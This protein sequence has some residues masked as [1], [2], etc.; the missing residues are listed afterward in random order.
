MNLPNDTTL[1]KNRPRGANAIPVPWAVQPPQG[2]K[3]FW[4]ALCLSLL[5]HL[6]FV[7]LYRPFFNA[8]LLPI[9]TP[10]APKLQE[11]FQPIVFEL[12]ETPADAAV[13]EP[14]ND[15][16]FFSDKNARASDLLERNDLVSGMPYSTGQTDYRV[17]SGGGEA[18]PQESSVQPQSPQPQDQQL[19]LEQQVSRRQAVKPFH[20]SML[21]QSARNDQ[22]TP[23]DFSD[24]VDFNQQQFSADALGDVSLNT[25][26]WD[27]APYLLAMKNKIRRNVY[28]PPA[29]SQMGMISG[30][31]V[32]RFRVY[33]DGSVQDLA[34][35]SYSGHPALMET[36]VNAVKASN[37]FK[38]LPDFFPEDYLELTWTF[39]YSILR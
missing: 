31:T 21:R 23:G 36:S 35:L 2:R 5:F 3:G 17:F 22:Q 30:E 27:F 9:S 12:V 18:T 20:A 25:Y 15:S 6:V 39:I 37:P 14:Q 19:G 8:L 33:P 28:P 26:A 38:Q 24:D 32:L 16:R 13:D 34:V 7:F 29:F 1:R 4:L 10:E 11:D